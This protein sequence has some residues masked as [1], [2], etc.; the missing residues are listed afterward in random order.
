MHASDML[1]SSGSK[2]SS[3]F[4][5]TFC[6]MNSSHDRGVQ[7]WHA[8]LLTE[9]AWS[10]ERFLGVELKKLFYGVGSSVWRDFCACNT[11]GRKLEAMV[12]CH[13]NTPVIACTHDLFRKADGPRPTT[14]SPCLRSYKRWRRR[15]SWR[16]PSPSSIGHGSQACLST[17]A[18]GGALCCLFCWRGAPF[19]TDFQKQSVKTSS[20]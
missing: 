13:L 10:L 15:V 12:L 7:G 19:K 16:S 2:S 4:A 14:Q 8:S 5:W 20:C 11:C 3:A 18:F 17:Q 9:I 6:V 1:W